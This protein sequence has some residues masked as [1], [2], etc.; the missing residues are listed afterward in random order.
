MI[1]DIWKTY[2]AKAENLG[3]LLFIFFSFAITVIRA[4]TTQMTFDEAYTYLKFCKPSI[5]H[6]SGIKALFTESIA[7]NH[8]LNTYL[9]TLFDYI[10]KSK[11]CEFIIRLPSILFYAVY[12][13]IVW[14]LYSMKYLGILE[15]VLLIANYYLDEFFGL[16]RGYAMAY[17]L[18]FLTC[19]SYEAW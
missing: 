10:F 13:L 2:G 4:A 5:Y 7:N 11:Y 14:K 12:L 15:T 6:W 17:M 9:I 16:A 8:L 3:I 19:L 1:R 18:V